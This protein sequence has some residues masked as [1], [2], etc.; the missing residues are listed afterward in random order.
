MLVGLRT[1]VYICMFGGPWPLRRGGRLHWLL[2]PWSRGLRVCS[3]F[4]F[5][6]STNLVCVFSGLWPLGVAFIGC[7]AVIWGVGVRKLHLIFFVFQCLVGGLAG[8][9]SG[10]ARPTVKISKILN[11]L[12]DLGIL[13][14]LSMSIS[15]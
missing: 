11:V 1:A 7:T 14:G 6:F 12:S 2:L 10:R 4:L 9:R 13:V 5:W 3:F 15:F 8:F